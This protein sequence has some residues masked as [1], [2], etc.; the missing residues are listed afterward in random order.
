MIICFFWYR[1][2][3]IERCSC[4]F[5]FLILTLKSLTSWPFR[6]K[7]FF[8]EWHWTLL[9]TSHCWFSS[10][11][12]ASLA[13]LNAVWIVWRYLKSLF[14]K[15]SLCSQYCSHWWHGTVDLWDGKQGVPSDPSTMDS[16]C[17]FSNDTGL[18]EGVP[19]DSHQLYCLEWQW[20]D[21]VGRTQCAWLCF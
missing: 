2:F 17:L 10:W 15:F 20:P 7:L 4:G 5:K 21:V 13:I 19:N 9:K 6:R 18:L 11:H 3:T 16:H 12:G 14:Q 8:E 1:V